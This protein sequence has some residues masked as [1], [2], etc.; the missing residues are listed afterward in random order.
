MKSI[1]R[2]IFKLHKKIYGYPCKSEV[3][4]AFETDIDIYFS[5]ICMLYICG[6]SIK[7]I[8]KS[9]NLDEDHVKKHL[10]ESVRG[11]IL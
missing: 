5:T 2:L 1:A 10:N 11:V 7:E 3:R 4:L 8:S 9:M 6:E